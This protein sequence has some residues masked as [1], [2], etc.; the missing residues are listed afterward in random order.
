MEKTQKRTSPLDCRKID[1]FCLKFGNSSSSIRTDLDK[2][3]DTTGNASIALRLFDLTISS[4]ITSGQ[5]SRL[6]YDIFNNMRDMINY[7]IRDENDSHRIAEVS[8]FMDQARM[9]GEMQKNNIFKIVTSMGKTMNYLK[10]SNG[11]YTNADMLGLL[12]SANR[13]LKLCVANNRIKEAV[14]IFG[15]LPS[16]AEVRSRNKIGSLIKMLER[17]RTDIELDVQNK[18]MR[19]D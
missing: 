12:E 19:R 7:T 14:E 9:A 8:S 10:L 11:A 18:H 3:I 6:T 5:A 16:K 15:S 1:A 13:F 4:F 17:S 2:I